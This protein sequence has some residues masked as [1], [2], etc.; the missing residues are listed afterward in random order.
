[1]DSA[2]LHGSVFNIE[3]KRRELENQNLDRYEINRWF[4]EHYRAFSKKGAFTC[5]CC[6]KTVNMNLT[7]DEGRPF[8]FKHNDENE[9][10]Y[11]ENT[12]TYEKHVTQHENKSKK[13]MGLTVFREILEGQL[14]PYGAIIERG[15]HYKKK[16]SF[17]PDFIVSFPASQ[18]MWTIDYY[19]AIAQGLVSGSYARNLAKRMKTYSDEGFKIFSFV[20][21]SWLS[22]E[23]ESNKGTLL[24]AETY[25]T[26]KSHEDYLWD[27]FLKQGLND[28]LLIFFMK[29]TGAL[30]KNFNT[31][32]IAYVDISNRICTIYRFI[33]TSHNNR[34]FTF[35]RLSSS[36]LPLDKALTLDT[37]HNQ[38]AYSN[39]NEE[40]K[41]NDLLKKLIEKR[42]QL[43]LEQRQK[44]EE[45]ARLREEEEK[46]QARLQAEHEEWLKLRQ[47]AKE[48]ED[49]EIEKEMQERA[50]LAALRP[51][52]IDPNR[53]GQSYSKQYL[54]SNSNNGQ[55]PSE[56]AFE[57]IDA[58]IEKERKE[59]VKEKLLSHPITGEIYIN[60]DNQYW[61]KVILKWINENQADE[62][63]IVSII[64]L[65]QYMKNSGVSFNQKDKL[66][67]HPIKTFLEFYVKTLNTELKK[68]VHLT[69]SE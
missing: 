40:D 44:E 21:S 52:G 26:N 38:F 32:N 47:K 62:Y 67:Q 65:L 55:K 7:K 68:K 36:N 42:Q 25:V 53:W 27:R 34:N 35:Y 46:K 6:N 33:E 15:F 59:K 50:K 13:D 8:Y 48:L 20:D 64:V 37:T 19:T 61:R 29:E 28:E 45:Q 12:K 24:T 57:S 56:S 54:Y 39:M 18:E 4:E 58:R 63:L 10:S 5:L 22:F 23:K 30:S 49:Q 1:M 9:C 43:E 69:I 31:Q 2:I 14:K 17:I 16:L 11:S 41:R 3:L 60:G 66:V 51:I